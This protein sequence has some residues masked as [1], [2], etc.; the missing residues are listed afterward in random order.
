MMRKLIETAKIAV[1]AQRT[2]GLELLRGVAA[3]KPGENV[4]LSPLS[5]FLALHMTENGAAGT[6]R[7]AMRKALAL[8]DRDA[9]HLNASSGA[10]Q[11]FLLKDP[12]TLTIANALWSDRHFTLAPEFVKL[13]DAT[14]HAHAAS[15]DFADPQASSAI[16]DWVKTNTNGKIP[17]IVTPELVRKAAVILTNAVYFAAQWRSEFQASNT[18]QEAFHKTGGVVKQVP[19]MHQSLIRGAYRSGGNFEGAMLDYKESSAYFY[20]LLPRPGK[21]PKDVLASLDV[22]HLTWSGR[23]EFDLDLKLSCVSRSIS[24][25]VWLRI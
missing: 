16:N 1:A 19:M 24:R 15:L 18:A 14:F 3:R 2:F 8:P 5:V 6:T 4:F 25:P 12:G 7:T 21:T 11:S 23:A 20:A 17:S 22:D 9:A 13:C 10:L